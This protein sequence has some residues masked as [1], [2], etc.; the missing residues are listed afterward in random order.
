[1]QIAYDKNHMH[2]LRFIDIKLAYDYRSEWQFEQLL[3]S[4]IAAMKSQNHVKNV[5]RTTLE[6]FC[7]K[8]GSKK[9]LIDK[10]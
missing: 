1:M 8:N 3:V 4:L 5:F 6:L 2:E 9:H 7:A 10:K